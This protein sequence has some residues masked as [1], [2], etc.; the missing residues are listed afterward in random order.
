MCMCVRVRVRVC[1]RMRTCVYLCMC[2]C[3]CV[4]VCAR[5]CACVCVCAATW[6]AVSVCTILSFLLAC[7]SSSF[8]AYAYGLYI[9]VF[10]T[11]PP[12]KL[13][14]TVR[15]VP[16]RGIFEVKSAATKS[17]RLCVCVEFACRCRR[18][19]T[20][21]ARQHICRQNPGT[22]HSPVGQKLLVQHGSRDWRIHCFHPPRIGQI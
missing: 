10:K 18:V 1:V 14:L 21:H 19:C 3:V 6:F 8:H 7:H 9:L 4:C 2:V 15:G 20:A 11:R 12:L 16:Q 22:Q 5:V 13:G 17:K